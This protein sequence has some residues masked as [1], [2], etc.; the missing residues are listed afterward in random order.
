MAAFT[1]VFILF[2]LFCAAYQLGRII[3]YVSNKIKQKLNNKTS[4]KID[5]KSNKHAK[6]SKDIKK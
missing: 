4:E 2:I 5:E 3:F 1:T 6:E